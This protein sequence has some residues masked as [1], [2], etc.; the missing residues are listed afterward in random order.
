MNLRTN[1]RISTHQSK[2]GLLPRHNRALRAFSTQHL[3]WIL[4]CYG[5]SLLHTQ[6][7]AN[8]TAFLILLRRFLFLCALSLISQASYTNLYWTLLRFTANITTQYYFQ[9]EILHFIIQ[10]IIL[11]GA[12]LDSRALCFNFCTIKRISAVLCWFFHKS[13]PL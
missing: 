8:Y 5:D 10:I 2:T 3:T 1:K 9:W 7:K 12:L 13:A 6:I 4:F 11:Y